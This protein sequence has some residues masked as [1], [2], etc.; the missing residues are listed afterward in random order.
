[1]LTFT[2]NWVEVLAN[3]TVM[4]AKIDGVIEQ[5]GAFNRYQVWQQFVAG[6]AAF[7]SAFHFL[8]IV[9]HFVDVKYRYVLSLRHLQ[10][11]DELLILILNVLKV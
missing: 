2:T 5:I 8:M 11:W 7:V 1:M 10:K 6:L 4:S 9:F 3:T